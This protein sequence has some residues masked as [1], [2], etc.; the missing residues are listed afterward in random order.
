MPPARNGPSPAIVPAG[1]KAAGTMAE[2]SPYA[3]GAENAQA[4]QRRHQASVA[5]LPRQQLL[6]GEPPS[7]RLSEAGGTSGPSRAAPR[8]QRHRDSPSTGL[9][10]AGC[11]VRLSRVE[12]KVCTKASAGSATPG[13][14]GDSRRQLAAAG[15]CHYKRQQAAGGS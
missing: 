9:S 2:K 6:H 8:Q 14:A 11:T 15:S 7:T 1:Q 13:C 12:P 5:G 3:Q 4:T 10:E